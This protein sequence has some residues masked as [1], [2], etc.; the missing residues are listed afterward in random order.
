MVFNIFHKKNNLK[1]HTISSQ[2]QVKE[3]IY[4]LAQF[5][6]LTNESCV[7]ER[8]QWKQKVQIFFQKYIWKQQEVDFFFLNRSKNTTQALQRNQIYLILIYK[9]GKDKKFHFSQ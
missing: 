2:K 5:Q 9:K 8:P 6:C 1:G 3:K 4:A 7:E